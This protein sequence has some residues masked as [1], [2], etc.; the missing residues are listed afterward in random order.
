[1]FKG[2]IS[3][4]NNWGTLKDAVHFGKFLREH[5][6]VC[7]G[8]HA[9]GVCMCL[10]CQPFERDRQIYMTNLYF[11]ECKRSISS[12]NSLCLQVLT[13]EEARKIL[14]IRNENN[15]KQDQALYD[16]E[17]ERTNLYFCEYKRCLRY[18]R[19]PAPQRS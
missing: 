1:M 16:F 9:R 14:V 7:V 17:G 12:M 6:F 8:V 15:E 10:V 2:L 19:A 18:N 3:Y 11:R 5:W 13:H 4:Q